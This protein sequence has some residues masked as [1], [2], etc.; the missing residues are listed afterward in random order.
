MP[1]L[2]KL[3]A[4][5]AKLDLDH[6]QAEPEI[7]DHAPHL[8]WHAPLWLRITGPAIVVAVILVA[9]F[10]FAYAGK[11]LPGVSADGVNV[12][13]SSAADATQQLDTKLAA[14]QG[15][16]IPV[17]YAGG[18]VSISVHSLAVTYDVDQA[19][20]GAA[21]IGREGSIMHRIAVQ[22][23]ALIGGTTNVSSFTFD[24]DVLAQDLSALDDSV[25]SPVADASVSFAGSQAQV[26][27]EQAGARLD[28]GGAVALISGQLASTSNAA[29]SA[30]VYQLQPP[31]ATGSL[32]GALNQI[33]TAVAAPITI[34][35]DGTTQTIDQNTIMSWMDVSESQD[36]DFLSTLKLA[37]LFPLMPS[38]NLGLN[39]SK[40]QAYVANLAS[41]I[42]Q[43]AQ[44]ATLTWANNALSV[45]KPSQDGRALDQTDAYNQIMAS[46]NQPTGG[47][48]INLKIQN[49]PAAVNENNLASLGITSQLSDGVTNYYWSPQNR[50]TN[51][52]L[53]L[54]QF[55]D[56]LL[57]PGEEF[58]FGKILGPA[59]PAQGYTLG[60]VILSNKEVPAYGGG[61]CQVVTTA[62]R[63]A[64]LAGLPITERTNHAFAISYYTWPYGVPGV[65]ATIYYPQL[66]FRFANDTGHYILI[67][68]SMN[69]SANTVSFDLYGT[70]AKVGVIRGPYF[71]KP[72]GSTT[73]D[74]N[75]ATAKQASHTIFYRDIQD[76]SGNV[77]KTDTFNTYYKPSTDFPPESD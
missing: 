17:S 15:D 24:H 66:D 5:G 12:S 32:A 77:T 44:D 55:N 51:I 50:L 3:D 20:A 21:A 49:T 1:K 4:I 64:L 72:D 46:L 70:K 58:S 29:V 31:L 33:D 68:T 67:Q 63:A 47:R 54:N 23:H 48:V 19:I 13:G 39:P 36:D 62:F 60:Y 7:S 34:N 27:P 75:Y 14:Y 76:L 9:S 26:N 61:I 18:T 38:V 11:I 37:N 45:V 57:A 10:E 42:D 8:A 16:V 56:V 25:V 22:F 41:K 73:S 6:F 40:V 52:G 59:T 35:N 43:P 69:K 53:G 2:A 30:P 65:D 71:V 28:V 74:P